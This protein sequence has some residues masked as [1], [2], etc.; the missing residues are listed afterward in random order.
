M[1]G[2]SY[3]GASGVFVVSSGGQEQTEVQLADTFVRMYDQVIKLPGLFTEGFM[4]TNFLRHHVL[5]HDQHNDAK[6]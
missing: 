6:L 4:D 2:Y 3:Y 1:E 5:L